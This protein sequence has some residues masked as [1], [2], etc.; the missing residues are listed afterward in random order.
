MCWDI[1]KTRDVSV[2]EG[3]KQG[4]TKEEAFEFSLKFQLGIRR[5]K[6]F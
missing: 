3:V 4:F 6:A 1:E 2:S 5:R